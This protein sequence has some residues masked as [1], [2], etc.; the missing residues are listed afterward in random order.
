MT[1]I[2]CW[3]REG[4]SYKWFSQIGLGMPIKQIGEGI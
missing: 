3:L 4:G 2:D 1:F